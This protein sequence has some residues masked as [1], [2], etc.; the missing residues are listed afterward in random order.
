MV[1]S[2]P[3]VTAVLIESP[4]PLPM[5]FAGG[6]YS[7]YFALARGAT[8]PGGKEAMEWRNLGLTVA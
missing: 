4:R 5:D 2:L 3:R 8:G 6:L 7:L 1:P